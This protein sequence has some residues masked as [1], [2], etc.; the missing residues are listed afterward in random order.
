RIE[1]YRCDVMSDGRLWPCVCVC[2]GGGQ[3]EMLREAVQ[4]QQQHGSGV[5]WKKVAEL[6]AGESGGQCMHRWHKVL[7][8]ELVKGPWT[9]E[10]AARLAQLVH[11]YGPKRWAEIASHLVGRIGKQCR[12][13]WHNHLNPS[14][15]K[16]SWT[17]DEDAILVE[18]QGRLGNKW[19]EIAKLLPGRTDN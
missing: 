9:P 6:F 11:E 10:E 17:G 15:N 4:A 1:V 12:E 16:A 19:A 5:E 8:P 14:I 18:A 7:D 13:R 2:G 3:D